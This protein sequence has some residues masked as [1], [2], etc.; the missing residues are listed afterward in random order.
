MLKW[1]LGLLGIVAIGY[2]A[3]ILD[4]MTFGGSEPT[5]TLHDA[6]TYAG[7]MDG[8]QPV[9]IRVVQVALAAFPKAGV[10]TGGSWSPH[11]IPIYSFQV[12]FEDG[13]TLIID[14]AEDEALAKG[15]SDDTAFDMDAYQAMQNAMSQAAKIVLTHEHPDHIGGL[16]LHPQLQE[17]LDV[18]D[19]TE[20][21]VNHP[22]RQDPAAFPE[23]A[24]EGYVPISYVD[25][26][27]LM[28][29]VALIKTPGHSPGSQMV[30]VQLQD[31]REFLFI[32]DIAWSMESVRTGAG[33]PRL[34]SWIFLHEDRAT[35]FKQLEA[36]KKLSDAAPDV[37]LVVAHDK[38]EME[39]LV[40]S[41][42]IIEGFK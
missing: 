4:K 23:D 40:A 39:R 20:E 18:T 14:T 34:M 12:V 27:A 32:G 15:L 31:G 17:I 6:R 36:L 24:L 30:L 16:T 1:I 25:Y 33:R 28:P 10:V 21:Q 26:R 9:E 13:S 8:P 35:V 42:D 29:G 22:E 3:L 7:S 5:F 2:Y 11:P 38:G 41:G 19:L 37:E